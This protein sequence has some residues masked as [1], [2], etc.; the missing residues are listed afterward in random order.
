MHDPRMAGTPILSADE[1]RLLSEARRAVL[2][3]L[4]PEGRPRLVPICHVLAHAVEP[5]AP[6]VLYTPID[7][8]PKVA[9]DPA[10]LARLRDIRARPLVSVLVDRWDEDWSRLAWVRVHGSAAILE[11]GPATR[12]E[13]DAA[14]SALRRK[15]PQ[16]VAQRIDDRPIIRIAIE[17]VRS[18]A[19]R[20]AG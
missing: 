20:P 9:A 16:Y 12:E 5:D 14:V 6:P 1:R 19:Y 13:H 15:Y 4:D 17:R 11:D 3:T 8:K 18:W 7:E 10:D 2:A